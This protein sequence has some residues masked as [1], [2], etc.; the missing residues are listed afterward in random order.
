MFNS[1]HPGPPR[2]WKG[3]SEQQLLPP[4]PVA[5]PD[6]LAPPASSKKLV[7]EQRSTFLCAK[8]VLSRDVFLTFSWTSLLKHTLLRAFLAGNPPKKLSKVGFR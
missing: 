4:L 7:L 1:R 3:R 8:V 2:V 6:P 5:P